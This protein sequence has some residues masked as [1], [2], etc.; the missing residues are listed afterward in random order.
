MMLHWHIYSM[1]ETV[2]TI[3][4]DKREDRLLSICKQAKQQDFAIKIWHGAQGDIPY[5]NINKAFKNIVRY[6]KENN[7]EKVIIAEDDCVFH[8]FQSFDYFIKNI[9]EKYHLYLGMVYS[10]QVDENHRIL[11][12]YSGNTLVCI[13]NSFY[14]FFLSAP[15]DVHLDRWCGMHAFEKIYY[16]CHPFVCKQLNG[17]SDN[18]RMNSTYDALLEG[19]EFV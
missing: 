2:H 5:K 19:K 18:R 12:G 16:V 1:V 9:P 4:L 3:N 13:H 11:N 10:A 7:L 14:D 6:A 17:Y 15:C 8:S